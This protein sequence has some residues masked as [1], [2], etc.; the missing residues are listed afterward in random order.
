MMKRGVGGNDQ[1]REKRAGSASPGGLRAEGTA[2]RAKA[3]HAK[4]NASAGRF[5]AGMRQRG[6]RIGHK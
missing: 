4:V 3:K 5:Y 2:I 6:P 1:G